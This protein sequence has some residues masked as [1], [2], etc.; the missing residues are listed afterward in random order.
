MVCGYFFK[1]GASSLKLIKGA[2]DQHVY[3]SILVHHDST[4]PKKQK[5]GYF[6]HDSDLKHTAKT[7]KVYVNGKR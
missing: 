3:K 1:K 6:Q 4:S 5:T 7:V 2:I